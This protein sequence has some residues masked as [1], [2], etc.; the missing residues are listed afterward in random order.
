MGLRRQSNSP[1]RGV[2]NRCAKHALGRGLLGLG[3]RAIEEHQIRAH[4]FTPE[5]AQHGG[6]L[7]SMV[8]CV[9]HDVQ[10]DPPDRLAGLFSFQVAV[11]DDAIPVSWTKLC[12]PVTIT[13]V[14]RLPTRREFRHTGAWSVVGKRTGR[15][16][17][18]A[19]EPYRIRLINMRQRP[20]DTTVGIPQI[21]PQLLG[22]EARNRVKNSPGRPFA[23]A[24]LQN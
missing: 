3:K 19:I 5:L 10:H 18:K 24:E 7:T 8:T 13:I 12:G 23:E 22:A 2:S 14:N 17:H 6:D 21:P 15:G 4:G 11:R 16:S 9:I 20:E 1:Y